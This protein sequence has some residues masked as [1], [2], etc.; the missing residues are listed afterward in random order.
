MARRIYPAGTVTA[1]SN[2]GTVL[3]GHVVEQ[4][5]GTPFEEYAEARILGPLRMERSTFRQP[6]PPAL[7]ADA[8]TSYAYN[9]GAFEA[10]PREELQIVPAGALSTTAA[11]MARFM[12]AHLE[13]GRV[14]DARLLR[15]ET[16]EEMHRQ[17]FTNDPRV[18][19][20]T[21][22]FRELRL[23]GQRLLLHTGT[24]QQ[25]R[26]QS[27]LALLPAERLGLF[28]SY[29]GG[30]RLAAE[31]LLQALLDRYYPAPAETPRPPADGA[32][33]D[34]RLF[35]RYRSTQRIVTTIDRVQELV[36]PTVGVSAGPDGLLVTTGL[37]P[38]PR[39]WVETA[40]LAFREVDG[41]ETLV[42]REDG[43]GRVDALLLGNL[44]IV[45]FTRM[46]WYEDPTL[47]LGVL[48]AGAILLLSAVVRWPIGALGRLVLRRRAARPSRLDGPAGWMAGGGSALFLLAAGALVAALVQE[49]PG[50]SP[51]LAVSMSSAVLAAALAVGTV[52]CA[53]PAWRRRSWGLA[54][55]VHYTL[56]AIA[57]VAFAW[58]MHYWNV[59]GFRV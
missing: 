30:N 19:G 49:T 21:Y 20:M 18:S 17:Q 1:Y 31:R 39:R 52:L 58:E 55:R 16:V 28:V 48:G 38:A 40:P 25:E 32:P 54:G 3:A 45:A 56:V 51:M 53:G 8:A 6:P 46:A 47:H 15:P 50:V 41:Q 42:F 27:T 12:L 23:N 57:L 4:V 59:L 10:T 14:G 43:Q 37:G 33:P 34:R 24:L 9:N 5:S 26:F 11:D 2:Y 36:A 7:A 13:G 22:G 29:T 44:P 35:G